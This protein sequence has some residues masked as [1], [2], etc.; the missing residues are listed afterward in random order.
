MVE[1]VSSQTEAEADVGGK[2]ERKQ[3]FQ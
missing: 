3:V 1:R 2:K